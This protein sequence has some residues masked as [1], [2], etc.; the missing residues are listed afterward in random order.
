MI[1]PRDRRR[2]GL[3]LMFVVVLLMVFSVLMVST[4]AQMAASR[5]VLSHREHQRQSLWLAR[6]GLELAVAHL[7]KDPKYRGETT[8]PIPLGLVR[9]T[10]EPDKSSDGDLL[11]TSE[12]SFPKDLRE[13]VVRSVSRRYRRVVDGSTVRMEAK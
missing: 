2:T 13:V 5:R 12:A 8:E 3:A 9:I 4:T 6:S 11:I 10:V 7:L 1:Y